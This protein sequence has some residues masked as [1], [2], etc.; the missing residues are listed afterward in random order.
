MKNSLFF[1][2][3]FLSTLLS[4]QEIPVNIDYLQNPFLVNP[5]RAGKNFN[6]IYKSEEELSQ[7][8]LVGKVLI[9]HRSIWLSN[10]K[11]AGIQNL[12]VDYKIGK[13]NEPSKFSV[14]FGGQLNHLSTG[15]IRKINS[16]LA[17]SGIYTFGKVEKNDFVSVGL[18]FGYTNQQINQY[19]IIAKDQNDFLLNSGFWNANMFNVGA[20]AC[21]K[22]GGL[23]L[24]LSFNNL[25]NANSKRNN[26]ISFYGRDK[27]V[28]SNY[29]L[30]FRYRFNFPKDIT[31]YKREAYIFE[32][33]FSSYGQFN[34]YTN[35]DL[36]FST[37]MGHWNNKPFDLITGLI[38]QFQ[39][40]QPKAETK[41]KTPFGCNTFLGVK[42]YDRYT[43]TAFYETTPYYYKQ[44]G[45]AIGIQASISLF[46]KSD[47]E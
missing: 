39:T 4:A 35:F 29:F 5:A 34:T 32:P 31:I 30:G 36:G 10:Q 18:N 13:E 40:E 38:F 14:G 47:F 6:L 9:S 45:Y 42:M 2:F 15:A 3:L 44:A 37:R 1:S 25:L 22:I 21:L 27:G 33:I 23:N 19:E 24:D 46:Q 43:I 12:S 17:V 8:R 7:Q 20:G 26:S 16:S 41:F 28:R 11:P